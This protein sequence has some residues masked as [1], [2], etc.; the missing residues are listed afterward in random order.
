MTALVV[1]TGFRLSGRFEDVISGDVVEHYLAPNAEV[2]VPALAP[3]G[4]WE[5]E[6]GVPRRARPV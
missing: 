4:F 3:E 1:W 6:P 2:Q 5:S